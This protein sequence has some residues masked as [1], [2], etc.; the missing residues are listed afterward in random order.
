MVYLK[1]AFDHSA[2]VQARRDYR[3]GYAHG[4]NNLNPE[5][6]N[7]YSDAYWRGYRAG[8]QDGRS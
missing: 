2:E 1:R 4:T 6:P 7:D 3:M 8:Q 5:Q